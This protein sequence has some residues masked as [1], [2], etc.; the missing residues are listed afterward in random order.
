MTTVHT[1]RNHL[2]N[3]R[4]ADKKTNISDH[5]FQPTLLAFLKMLAIFGLDKFCRENE[6][7][8]MAKFHTRKA[9]RPTRVEKTA[10]AKHPK[11]RLTVN[12][13]LL[14]HKVV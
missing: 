5:K 2:C 12:L 6:I 7:Q 1:K 13:D 8:S 11:R 10:S 3:E 14:V 9:P 4:L